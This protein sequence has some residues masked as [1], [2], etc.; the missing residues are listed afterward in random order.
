MTGR[1]Y[2]AGD[3]RRQFEF[4]RISSL[5]EDRPGPPFAGHPIARSGPSSAGTPLPAHWR[6][7]PPSDASLRT[8]VR[9]R[10]NAERACQAAE[11]RAP[12]I[13]RS[14]SEGS[15]PNN[16]EWTVADV[17]ESWIQRRVVVASEPGT[18][19]QFEPQLRKGK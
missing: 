18:A 17:G 2:A 7:K 9:S 12:V 13:Q 19:V 4:R 8:L 16:V 10:R 15:R 6:E 11:S 5:P 3:C 1:S 14:R